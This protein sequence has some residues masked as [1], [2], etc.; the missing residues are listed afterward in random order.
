MKI[1]WKEYEGK[2][3][4]LSWLILEAMVL[5]GIEKFGD[6]NS[7]CLEVELKANGLIVPLVESMDQLQKQLK[8]IEAEGRK[9]GLEEAK[10]AIQENI[11]RLLDFG[12]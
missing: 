5:V 6:F 1:D 4:V 10:Y 7:S 3:H 12:P 11:E 2:E 9:R 8:D